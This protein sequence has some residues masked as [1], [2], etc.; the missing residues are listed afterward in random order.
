MY[1]DENNNLS[2]YEKGFEKKNINI[3]NDDVSKY[4]VD[5]NFI[6]IH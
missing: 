3:N 4:L 5:Y 1:T 2:K 6:F